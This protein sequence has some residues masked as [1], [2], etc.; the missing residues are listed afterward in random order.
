MVWT[1]LNY[2]P[3]SQSQCR[4][5]PSVT[6]VSLSRLLSHKEQVNK[7]ALLSLSLPKNLCCSCNSFKNESPRGVVP[8][9]T[10]TVFGFATVEFTRKARIQPGVPMPS[11]RLT[12][13]TAR[14]TLSDITRAGTGIL[15]LASVSCPSG[16]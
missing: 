10:F 2:I 15:L 12:E 3:L 9:E 14:R 7:N 6:T 13:N 4:I 11:H 1:A 5:G 16:L 8:T